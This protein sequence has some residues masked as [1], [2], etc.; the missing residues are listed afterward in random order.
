MK[1]MPGMGNLQSMLGKMGMGGG[2][3]INT[4][5]MQAQL[6]K[7]MKMAKQ[8]ERMKSKADGKQK[9][10]TKIDPE[11]FKQQ[12]RA[13][14]QAAAELL[15]SEGFTEDGIENLVFSTGEKY[16]KSVRPQQ[17]QV[18]PSKKKKKKKKKEANKK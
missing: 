18:S 2:G 1:D 4:A 14:A 6:H 12:E 7:N 11:I 8:R 9:E 13:A 15:R 5:A 16:E 3:K 17:Q 10:N